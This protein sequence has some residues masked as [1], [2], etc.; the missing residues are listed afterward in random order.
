MLLH[1]AWCFTKALHV[2]DVE[3]QEWVK[4]FFYLASSVYLWV[5][6]PADVPC[7]TETRYIYYM[8]LHK[9]SPYYLNGSRHELII[10]LR[11]SEIATVNLLELFLGFSI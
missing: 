4:F 3:C 2:M 7:S 9:R 11:R 1:A 5:V 10:V 6:P 8:P